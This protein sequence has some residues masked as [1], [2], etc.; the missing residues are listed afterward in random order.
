MY[1]A[2]CGAKL[3]EGSKFCHNCGAPVQTAQ[4]VT[5]QP[6]PAAG[7]PQQPVQASFP[8][9]EIPEIQAEFIPEPSA[10]VQQPVQ[11]VS[12]TP[13]VYPAPSQP[14]ADNAG[15]FSGE[16][17]SYPSTTPA[18]ANGGKK[19]GRAIVAVIAI[20]AVLAGGYFILFGKGKGVL[21]VG[22]PAAKGKEAYEA[23]DYEAAV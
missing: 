13:P 23:G 18:R 2:N 4:P 7:V 8:S 15:G 6:A 9:E 17:P 20:L 21:P 22:D 16:I 19:T 3:D 5:Q 12:Y 10:Q 11:P 1:C 14:A